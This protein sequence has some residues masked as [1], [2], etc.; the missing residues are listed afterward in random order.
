MGY[1]LSWL[2]VS[3]GNK[4]SV[5]ESLRLR[6]TG[7]FAEFTEANDWFGASLPKGWYLIVEDHVGPSRIS[8]TGLV[9]L[10]RSGL[11]VTGQVEEHVMCS[12]AS[13]W[14]AGT[15]I[16][17][18]EHVSDRGL[19]HL[20][21]KGALPKEYESIRERLFAEQDQADKFGGGGD[22]IFDLPVEVSLALTGYRYDQDLDGSGEPRFERLEPVQ[23]MRQSWWRRFMG[24]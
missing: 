11:V 6:G 18:I 13:G 1:S 23:A 19:R 16:W 14:L 4:D 2:A 20:E 17:S 22:H 15:N 24:G 9:H 5:L 10:S 8:D 12:S 3:G 7:E 21:T